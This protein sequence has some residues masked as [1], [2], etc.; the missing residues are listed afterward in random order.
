MTEQVRQPGRGTPQGQGRAALQL[1]GLLLGFAS[2]A[3]VCL[4][5]NA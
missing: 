2:V 1:V 4:G 3:V 5:S